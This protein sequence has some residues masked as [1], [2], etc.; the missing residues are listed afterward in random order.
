[1]A[2]YCC[3]SA[4][5]NTSESSRPP[6][7]TM[8]SSSS[9]RSPSRTW[10]CLVT[11]ASPKS[12]L[13]EHGDEGG[14]AA[15][16]L[17]EARQVLI[18]VADKPGGV[19]GAAG[20]LE[21]ADRVAV[22]ALVGIDEDRVG[23]TQVHAQGARGVASLAGFGEALPASGIRFPATGGGNCPGFVGV[24]VGEQGVDQPP[25]ITRQ[26]RTGGVAL[27]L[28]RASGGSCGLQ[29]G[30]GGGAGD[31]LVLFASKRQHRVDVVA[32]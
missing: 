29:E 20:G 19:G 14:P 23:Q 5:R 31:A 8:V 2:W 27:G 7:M 32:V 4:R 11:A 26:H 25:G 13:V 18:E 17:S 24:A 9:R 22:D 30:V 15:V 28:P 1:M 10:R 21:V 6:R 16:L 12:R 3:A